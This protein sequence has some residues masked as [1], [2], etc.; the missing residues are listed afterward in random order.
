MNN[1]LKII[2]GQGIFLMIVLIAIYFI[3]PKTGLEVNG[4]SVNFKSINANVIMISENPDFSN[5]RYIEV[6][7]GK[8]SSFNLKPGK[9]YWKSD[10]GIISSFKN[11]FEIKSEVG[12]MIN[13]TENESNLV[14]IGNVKLKV[15]KSENGMMVGKIILEPSENEKI[16]D[17][18]ESYTGGQG[19]WK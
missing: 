11:E 8:N 3:Y 6:G 9:Y 4:N 15:S 16:E 14:N 13:K 19:E 10:N 2:I 17:K 7:E 1:H 5:S 12:M 18:N